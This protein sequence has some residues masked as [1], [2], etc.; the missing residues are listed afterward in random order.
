MPF[1]TKPNRSI[2]M[3][4]FLLALLFWAGSAAAE[5]VI[6]VLGDSLSAAH[7]MAQ[8]AG[9]VHLLQQR[10][11]R[12]GHPHRVVNASISGETSDGAVSRIHDELARW[13][14]AVVILELGA[15]DGLRGLSPSRLRNNLAILI[16][17]SQSHGARVL[18]LGM[19]LP[20]NYGTA[21]ARAFS[22]V[23]RELARRYALPFLP[24]L[25]QGLGGD[26]S[27]FQD[28]GLHPTA[29]AQ[30]LILDNVW[31]LLSP[32]LKA[33]PPPGGAAPPSPP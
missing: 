29:R 5:P 10:L 2:A 20:P 7:G 3:K 22:A 11:R 25:L 26:L 12:S 27:H 30:P 24:F 23:Y 8:S 15:N 31:P 17:A 21:Y 9:W 6:L 14:P 13:Q 1:H 16:E 4:P 33:M 18:L 19:R 32:L 28:D